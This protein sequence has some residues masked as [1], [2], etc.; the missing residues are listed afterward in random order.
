MSTKSDKTLNVM[1][2]LHDAQLNNG[3][4]R[5]L[6]DVIETLITKYNVKATVITPYSGRSAILYLE[7]LG[8]HCYCV[9]YGIWA[10]PENYGII[11]KIKR[12]GKI[13]LHGLIGFANINKLGK[14]I[15]DE[16]ID[17]IYSNTCV[18]Y[19]GA[20]LHDKYK[21]PHIWHIREFGKE[22]H[23]L[24]ILFGY[25]RLYNKMSN[26]T[27][28]IIYISNSIN[29]KYKPKI[30]AD[31]KQC[32][33]YND[34]SKAFAQKRDVFNLDINKPLN[35]AVI[36]SIQAG[37]GQ[38]EAIKA[39]EMAVSE[40]Y[41]CILHIA[42]N[43]SGEYYKK[44]L[45]YV[46]EHKL[47]DYVVFDGFITNVNEYRLQMDV[48]IVASSMEAFGRVTIEGMLSMM[49][50]IGANTAGTSEL[51]DDMNTGLLYELHNIRDLAN[52]IELLCKDRETM[53]TIATNGYYYAEDNFTN[54][55]AADVIY[56]LIEDLTLT[57]IVKEQ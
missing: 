26:S 28:T 16:K 19:M 8:A 31:V 53:K 10:Y 25:Q 29:K 21:I 42:G 4:V 43:P 50:M 7:K 15:K 37:K 46:N 34:I 27:D 49:A 5:S 12:I 9:K 23:G 38:M 55:K 47:N 11:R 54:G 6:V 36:G 22:D 51:I 56:G 18:I 57:G 2:L 14:I 1:F 20:L 48:G 17:V 24:Q 44:L 39:V 3:A 52:K 45:A 35:M 40:G 41:K 32:V 33:V 13:A 30:S